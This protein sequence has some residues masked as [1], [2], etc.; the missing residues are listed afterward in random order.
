MSRSMCQLRCPAD[1]QARCGKILMGSRFALL[2]SGFCLQGRNLSRFSS[3]YTDLVLALSFSLAR[4]A[5]L[6]QPSE[7]MS[8]DELSH[9]GICA[10]FQG[11][12]SMRAIIPKVVGGLWHCCKFHSQ[13]STGTLH[14]ICHNYYHMGAQSR[15]CPWPLSICARLFGL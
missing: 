13:A 2:A 6:L 5:V 3:S 14:K 9:T 8:G 1:S 7:W 15:A 10:C 11:Q 4:A 12:S